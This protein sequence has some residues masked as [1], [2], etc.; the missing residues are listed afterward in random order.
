MEINRTFYIWEGSGMKN[1]FLGNKEMQPVGDETVVEK[2]IKRIT[3]AIN[4]G[5]FKIGEKLPNEFELMEELHV[6]RNSLREAMKIMDSMGIVEIK[7]GN[8]TYICDQIRPTI[9]DSIIYGLILESSSNEEIIELRQ[10]LDEAV[11]KLAIKKCTD[12]DIGILEDYI[13]KMRAYFNDGE[14]SKAARTDYEFHLYLI[15]SCKNKFLARIVEGVYTLFEYS[16]EKN[17]RTEE[18]FAQADEH[19]QDIV[20]CLKSRDY[21]LVEDTVT[22]S[23]SSWK[24]NV[25]KSMAG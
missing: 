16:I 25:N 13:A 17:I 1:N 12:R 4:Q 11:L 5:R 18:L 2:I 21:S 8:G 24:A 19:H 22:R 15:E 3:E 23:L 7:R 14:I 6:S 20:N 9:F 10:T